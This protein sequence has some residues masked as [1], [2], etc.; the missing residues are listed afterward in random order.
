MSS[1]Y[2]PSLDAHK[3]PLL[4]YLQVVLRIAAIMLVTE[5]F[6][7][8]L[9]STPLF[10]DLTAGVLATMDALLLVILTSPLIYFFI[11]KPFSVARDEARHFLLKVMESIAHPFYV[12]D[13]NSYQVLYA[14]QATSDE[15]DRLTKT[16]YQLTHHRSTPCD[17]E[18]H[19][20]LQEIKKSKLPVTTEHL[21]YDGK[22]NA[23][24]VEVHGYPILDEKGKV[25]QMIEYCIDITKRKQAEERLKEKMDSELIH[26]QRLAT[27][28][29]QVSGFA[30]DLSTPISIAR[31]TATMI[32]ASYQRIEQ[33]LREEAVS[34]E[35]LMEQIN[36]IGEA[37]ALCD[38]NLNASNEMIAGFKRV[39]IDQISDD[40]RY[41]ELH[42]LISDTLFTVHHLFKRSKVMIKT[43][44]PDDIQIKGVP[45][46]LIQVL[47]NLLYNSLKHGF[48]Q[49]KESGDISIS[50]KRSA[51]NVFIEY[52][53]SGRGMDESV[54]SRIFER[55]FTTAAGSG[56]SGIG[57]F[58][59][60][61]LVRKQL[62]GTLECRSAPGEGATFM[63]NIPTNIAV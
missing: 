12:I 38:A 26:N 53:D 33:L 42:R 37:A 11:I 15:P 61:V 50:A 36:N 25:V 8:L 24:N 59:C 54:R 19:C 14:N 45:G 10:A 7:M 39:S 31:G 43:D 13:A 60:D 47:T 32:S 28:G 29:N 30:H 49:G 4:S 22:G 62:G 58:T 52:R 1:T 27:L 3:K 21:H 56:G 5:F 16:C 35:A 48:N 6:I 51:N 46:A 57:L 20:P 55:F 23:I 9:L 40:E 34:E 44:C 18:H 2:K 17:N 63:I 41:F